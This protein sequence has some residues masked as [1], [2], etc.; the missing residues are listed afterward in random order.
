MELPEYF[1]K[2][3]KQDKI[4]YAFYKTLNRANTCVIARLQTAKIPETRALRMQP[5]LE[6]E[7]SP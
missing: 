7:L 6:M 5:L 2:E 3:L 4:A 1:L